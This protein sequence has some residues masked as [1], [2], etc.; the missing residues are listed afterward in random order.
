MIR[1]THLA[2]A[3]ALAAGILGAGRAALAQPAQRSPEQQEADRHFKNGVARFKEGKFV[4]ALA[5]FEQANKISP[6][7]LVLYNIAGCYRELSRYTEA[8][9]FYRRFLDE[10][11]GKVPPGRLSDAKTELAS[12]YALVARVTVKIEPAGG[13]SLALDDVALDALPDAPLIL[14]PGDHKLIARAPGRE[15][16]Q[17]DLRVVAGEERTVVLTFAAPAGDPR[18]PPTGP[19]VG[20]RPPPETTIR[21][22]GP[23]PVQRA[24]KRFAVNAGFATNALRVSETDTGTASVGLGLAF[25]SGLEVGVDATLVAYSVI[26]SLRLRIAGD[27]LSLH[28]IAAAPISFTDGDEMKTFVAGAAGLGLRLRLPAMPS[29][30]LRLE[31]L[32]CFAGSGHGTTVPTFLGGELWF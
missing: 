9:K 16:A 7:P 31:S 24:P 5:E 1:S 8:V 29:L 20:L 22:P 2:L 13:A 3:L 6:H 12:I 30:A 21:T 27:A 32:A 14:S 4:D 19:T 23:P 25:G 18:R 15:P 28:A 10:G 11:P 17:S 26:P